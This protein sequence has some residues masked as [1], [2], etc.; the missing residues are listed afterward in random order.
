MQ[1]NPEVDIVRAQS[2]FV[3]TMVEVFLNAFELDQS[4]ELMY[5][6]D[7]I[8]PVIQ[9]MLNDYMN[10]DKIQF[11][12]AVDRNTRLILGW[13]SFGIIPSTGPVPPELASNEVTSWA[14]QKSRGSNRSCYRLAA[15]L[16]ERSRNGQS[17]NLPKQRL[18]I[19]TIV[20]EPKYKCSGVAGKLLRFAVDYARASD[21]TIWAQTPSAFGGLFRR[22][23]FYHVADFDLD[24]NDY[25]PPGDERLLGIETWAQFKLGTRAES[26]QE[27]QRDAIAAREHDD[28]TMGHAESS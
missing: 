23:G 17:Q 2:A 15:Q 4:V 3:D 28:D 25:K 20:T 9:Q 24:L 7:A 1:N 12:L 21:W 11:K 6:K 14:A 13:M 5:T 18:V 8:R 26:Q 16:E 19:N 10:D 22:N 27:N